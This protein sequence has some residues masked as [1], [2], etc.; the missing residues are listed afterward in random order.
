MKRMV[1][2]VGVLAIGFAALAQSAF[3]MQMPKLAEI[4]SSY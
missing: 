4:T 2:A 3:V 1:L